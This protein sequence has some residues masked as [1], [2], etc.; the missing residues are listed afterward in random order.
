MDPETG[1]VQ[2][3]AFLTQA[4]SVS[5]FCLEAVQVLMDRNPGYAK[6]AL[7]PGVF[8]R[9]LGLEFDPKPERGDPNH[10]LVYGTKRGQNARKLRDRAIYVAA[11]GLPEQVYSRLL[12]ESGIGLT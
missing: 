2:S 8:C 10:V 5:V 9:D 12:S 1:R 11:A 6:L 3:A 7:L 4:L